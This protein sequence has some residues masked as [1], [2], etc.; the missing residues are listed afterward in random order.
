MERAKAMAIESSEIA[1]ATAAGQGFSPRRHALR[2]C[3]DR[4]QSRT[5]GLQTHGDLRPGCLQGLVM[6]VEPRPE[7]GSDL[8]HHVGGRRG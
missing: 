8:H 3:P 5:G 1:A 7:G 2:A 6:V 4:A